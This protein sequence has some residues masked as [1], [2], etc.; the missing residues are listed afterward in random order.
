LY[1][2]IHPVSSYTAL[3]FPLITSSFI[4]EG[5]KIF[6]VF[7]C[8]LP[9]LPR[10]PN[11]DPCFAGTKWVDEEYDVPSCGCVFVDVAACVCVRSDGVGF[12]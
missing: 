10:P 5:I 11:P 2:Y 7:G 8:T 9:P 12:R 1:T 6:G 4:E 3:H